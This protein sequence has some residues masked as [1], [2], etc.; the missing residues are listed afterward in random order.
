MRKLHPSICSKVCMAVLG[1][2][3][4]LASTPTLSQTAERNILTWPVPETLSP[5]GAAAMASMGDGKLPDPLPPIADL[6][7]M[8]DGLQTSAG[9]QLVQRYGVRVET[10][11][12]AGVP[13]RIIY[14]KGHTVLGKGPVLINLHG[15]GFSLDS[16]SMTETV[17]IAA[18]TGVPV[19]AVLYRLAP[20]HPYPAAVDDALAVYRMLEKEHGARHIAVFGTSAGA[21]LSA[22][23]IS[24]LQKLH[25]L[26]PAA[27]GFLSGSADLSRR[28]DSE[29][30]MPNPDRGYRE[31]YIGK[32]A[33]TDP[34]F[35]PQ[36]GDLSNFPPTLLMTSTRDFLL[37]PTV[38][39]ARALDSAGI[40]T[41][42]EVF[43]GLPHAF[44]SYMAIPETDQANAVIAR[45]LSQKL[46]LLGHR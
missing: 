27:L 7:R 33:L 43:D 25:Y 45:F 3:L 9:G 16:G 38:N 4:A 15:G 14:P 34:A 41:K 11:S 46:G 1:L 20:D 5:E 19:V 26:M 44:W 30:W 6:R 32:T 22:Q 2:S 28:G 17:P 23:L 21:V 31:G 13:V 42:L 18:L 37:S 40:D 29:S 24:R 39:F 12:I 35:S 36:R 10:A 8:T